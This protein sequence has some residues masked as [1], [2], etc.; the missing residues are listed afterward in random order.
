MQCRE[1]IRCLEVLSPVR[2]AA[3]WDNV[4]LLLGREDKDVK[5]VMLAVDATE[6]VIDRAIT[7]GADMLI[8]HH[9]LIFKPLKR[10][11]AEDFIGKRVLNLLQEDICYYAMHTNFD[12]MGM[13]DAAADKIGLKDRQVLE[14]TYEDSMN[15]E[16]YGRYG[17]LP[18]SMTL[19]ECA[20]FVKE[21][22][23]IEAVSVYG[24]LDKNVEIAAI[25][26]GSVK[27][28]V[29]NAVAS[30]VDVLISGDFDH[31]TGLDLV[32]RDVAV[33]DAGHY[34][35]EKIFVPYMKEY[36]T[37]QLPQLMVETEKEKCPYK[38]I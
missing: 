37:K 28:V 18:K 7:W 34:G 23:G 5:K 32:A 22:F 26:P 29:E 10:I 15:K 6:E 36:L 25:S 4:G 12:V 31:H 27:S 38:I 13:A 16:G 9:P 19:E 8:T 17:R 3:G 33:I 2:Y 21:T 35:L 11:C 14:V 30:G 24:E 1:I 20:Y